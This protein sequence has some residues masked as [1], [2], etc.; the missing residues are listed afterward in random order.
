M[1]RFQP[2]CIC[3][4][5]ILLKNVKYNIGREYKLYAIISLGQRSKGGTTVAVKKEIAHK[6]LNTRTTLQTV[7]SSGGLNGSEKKK[8][9]MIN[10]SPSNRPSDRG[11]YEKSPGTAP[12]TYDLLGDFNV[13][14]PLW[15]SEKMIIK[16][17]MLEKILD[18]FNLLCLKEKEETYYR[19][20]NGCK[21]TIDLTFANL[22]R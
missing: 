4:Q 8:D 19:A 5:E 7:S 17:R 16:G 12:S 6:I 14:N 1:N 15:R 2:S 20:N 11:R 3:L 18:R 9:N 22:T 13:H 10:I 21:S